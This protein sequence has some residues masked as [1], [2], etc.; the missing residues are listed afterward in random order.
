MASSVLT[1]VPKLVLCFGIRSSTCLQYACFLILKENAS[2]DIQNSLLPF[3]PT[4]FYLFKFS[5]IVIFP[6][7]YFVFVNAFLSSITLS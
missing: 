1:A 3:Y 5:F 4:H 2:L 6:F 7:L